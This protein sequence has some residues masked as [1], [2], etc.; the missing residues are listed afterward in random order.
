MNIV[1][2]LSFLYLNI[3]EVNN[4]IFL[5]YFLFSFYSFIKLRLEIRDRKSGDKIKTKNQNLN[6]WPPNDHTF[7]QEVRSSRSTRSQKDYDE[8]YKVNINVISTITPRQ[9]KKSLSKGSKLVWSFENLF[10]HYFLYLLLETIHFSLCSSYMLEFSSI[11]MYFFRLD[12]FSSLLF[13]FMYYYVITSTN[14]I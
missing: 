11:M 2:V 9:K 1:W 10:F 3:L 7:D 14:V 6:T 12:T 8:I 13:I 4:N 5:F